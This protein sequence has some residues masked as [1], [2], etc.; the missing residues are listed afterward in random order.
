MDMIK[1][2]FQKYFV[3]GSGGKGILA[4]VNEI[5]KSAE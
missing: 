4:S 5:R 1:D 3:M 2:D